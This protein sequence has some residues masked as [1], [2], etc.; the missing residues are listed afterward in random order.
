MEKLYEAAFLSVGRG[1]GFVGLGIFTLMIGLSFDPAL[2]LKSGGIL[3]LILLAALLLQAQRPPSRH[4][5]EKEVWLLLHEDHRPDQRYAARLLA[6]AMRDANLWFAR[7]T[8]GLA[9]AVWTA[10]IIVSALGVGP[11]HAT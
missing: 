1:V 2:A 7:W 6:S 8:A 4:Y 5:R 11:V 9:V 10:A 3:L